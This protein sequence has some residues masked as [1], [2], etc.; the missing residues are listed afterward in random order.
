MKAIEVLEYISKEID[1]PISNFPDGGFIIGTPQDKV[2][3]ILVTWMATSQALRKAAKDGLN[4]VICHE[5][6]FFTEKKEEKQY[7]WSS[8]SYKVST[9]WERH[10]NNILKDI[11]IKNNLTILWIHYGLDR[12]CIY[13]AFMRHLGIEEV[14][15]GSAYEKIYRLPGTM[16]LDELIRYIGEKMNFSYIRYVGNLNNKIRGVG[17]CWGGVSLSQ[18]RYWMRR[19]IENGAQAIICGELDE[20]A[21]FF[22]KEC[23]ISLIETSHVLSENI[24]LKEFVA[25][26]SH[27]FKR[28]PVK[29]YEMRVPYKIE[30]LK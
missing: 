10:P 28:I 15:S 19:L 14:V 11:A 26:L 13:E 3:G 17:N 16:A 29:F 2:K 23:G 30:A 8:T 6:F 1:M 5:P 7:R 12:F 4:L 18:N 25:R 27:V 22:A 9:N 24:G 20:S 21:M